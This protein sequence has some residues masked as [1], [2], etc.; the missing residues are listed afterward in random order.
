VC[1]L[2]IAIDAVP[3]APL[4]LLGNR[5]EYHARPSAPAAPW[6]EDA[7]VAGG[8]DRVGGGAWLAVRSNGRFAAVT[9]LRSGIPAGAPRSRGA[10]VRDFVLDD[11]A[12][13]AFLRRLAGTVAEYGPFN[14]VLGNADVAFAFGSSD[15]QARA[16]ERGV[17]VVSNGPLYVH[18]PKTRRLEEG[19]AGARTGIDP[20]T[21]A[22]DRDSGTRWL[23]LLLD[24]TQP[25]DESLPDTGVGSELER[26]LAPVFIRGERYGTRAS[27]L[28][29]RSA[30]GSWRLRERRFGPGGRAAGETFLEA[31]ADDAFTSARA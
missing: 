31:A 25:A 26:R 21:G 8:R 19:F 24:E 14:L 16:L 17:H 2:L 9:N 3:G 7:R 12:P 4:L 29:L 13:A 30:D 23:D 1:L 5:D 15:G 10:L 27:T 22:P 18:W 6:P 20:A 11:A 28:A